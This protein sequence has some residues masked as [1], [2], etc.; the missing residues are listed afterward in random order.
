MMMPTA[1]L[2]GGLLH[3]WLAPLGWA[4]PYLIGAMLFVTFCRVSIRDMRFSPLHPILLGVQLTLSLAL[5]FGVG[6]YD[7][8]VA[9]GLM[10]CS[11]APTAMAAVVVAGMLGAD[12]VTMA[13]Y[14]LLSNVAV[15][16][17][18]PV[19]F[20]FV[21]THAD[22]PFWHSCGVIFAKVAPLLI[23][24]LIAAQLL[25][26]IWPRFHAA[27]KQRQY[28]SFYLWSM[29]LTVVTARTVS[30]IV[31]QP[32]DSYAVEIWLG[33]GALLLCAL[34]FVV[35]RL[36]GRHYGDTVA[37]GQSLGQKNTVL[38]IWMAQMYLSP[39]ASVGPA[40]YILWQN[41]VNSYQLWRHSKRD[42]NQE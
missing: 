32:S 19:L 14:T 23:A 34:Q 33:A 40:T 11:F 17:L 29:S 39:L 41:V 16:I 18:A 12:V 38:A 25:E 27:V 4:M 28:I 37:G 22:M 36:I 5:Y 8:C 3:R 35:G 21:G 6:L 15:A 24:P 31:A 13:M 26:R 1:M 9:E 2:V 20:S 42:E 30:F 7:K 10:I